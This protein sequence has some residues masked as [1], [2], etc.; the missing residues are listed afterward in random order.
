[1]TALHLGIFDQPGEKEI[2]NNLLGSHS[3]KTMK[4]HIFHLNESCGTEQG[5]E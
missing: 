2:F 1:L 3:D 5:K 4:H